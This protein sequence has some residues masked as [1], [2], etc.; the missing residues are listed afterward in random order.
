MTRLREVS[1]ER[2]IGA[3]PAQAP[4][5]PTEPAAP[6][7][8]AAAAQ[9]LLLALRALAQR[10][11]TA[12]VNSVSLIGLGAVAALA[13]RISAAPTGWQLGEL[14]IF[15]IFVLALRWVWVRG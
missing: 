11:F 6:P 2:L 1:G 5:A 7:M 4:A 3:E 10:T 12:L 15:A 14:G 9:A 8:A 13:W